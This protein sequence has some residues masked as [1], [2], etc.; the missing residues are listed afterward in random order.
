MSKKAPVK[1]SLISG[2]KTEKNTTPAKKPLI[3]RRP[4]KNH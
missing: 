4:L 2:S 1:K 3:S